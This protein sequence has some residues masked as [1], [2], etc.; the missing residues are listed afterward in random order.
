[1]G[2]MLIR[3]L[4]DATVERYRRLAAIN[5]RSLEAEA[6]RALECGVEYAADDKR[7][8]SASVRAITANPK[9]SIEGWQLIREGRDER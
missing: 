8:L 9:G 4:N 1:M 2:Q 6:R 3:R 7:A 5:G